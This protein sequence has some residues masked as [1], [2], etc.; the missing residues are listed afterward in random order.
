MAKEGEVSCSDSYQRKLVSE[1][2]EGAGSVKDDVVQLFLTEE[3][4]TVPLTLEGCEPKEGSFRGLIT[5]HRGSLFH[6]TWS[7]LL[8]SSSLISL[9]KAPTPV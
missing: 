1:S 3:R 8:S 2:L 6:P 9:I 7:R 4:V 5:S